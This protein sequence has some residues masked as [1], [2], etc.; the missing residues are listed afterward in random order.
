MPLPMF[1]TSHLGVSEFVFLSLCPFHIENPNR[2]LI[3][4]LTPKLKVRRFGNGVVLESGLKLALQ[5]IFCT[6]LAQ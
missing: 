5:R 4:P 3:L 1:K 6:E 2:M